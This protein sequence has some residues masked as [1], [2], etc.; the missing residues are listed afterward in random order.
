[1]YPVDTIDEKLIP[2]QIDN[3]IDNETFSE[4][5][6]PNMISAASSFAEDL[7]A[8]EKINGLH[9]MRSQLDHEI[10][11]LKMLQEKNKDIRSEEIEL[12]IS[13]Q[14]KLAALIGDARV[15]IDALQLIQMS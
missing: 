8:L 5:I 11:R 2:G 15:R 14:T 12:A 3:L 13:E 1:M 6:I 9:K 4:V 10:D 7:G